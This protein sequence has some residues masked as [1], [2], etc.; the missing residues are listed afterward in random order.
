MKMQKSISLTCAT[1]G[2]K[3]DD[4]EFLNSKLYY[5]KAQKDILK[6]KQLFIN[7][8]QKLKSLLTLSESI[9]T[10]FEIGIEVAKAYI[11]VGTSYGNAMLEV[12]A[13]VDDQLISNL[14][15]Q[16]G[17]HTSKTIS[18]NSSIQQLLNNTRI[19][20][21]I[22]G[23]LFIIL[24]IVVYLF[25]QKREELHQ[26]HMKLSQAMDSLW[27]EMQL[28][29]KIQTV[30]LPI[31]PKINGFEISGIMIPAD[32]VGG[33]YFDVINADGV[34]WL[35]IGDVSGHGVPAGLIMMMAQTSI[36]TIL[37]QHPNISPSKLLTILNKV[38]SKNIKNLG[39]EKYMT[40]SALS[41]NDKGEV[42][43]SGLHQDIML[44]RADC[45]MV[46]RIETNGIW[47][48]IFDDIDRISSDESF[49]MN[50]GDIV[51]LFTDG[52]TEATDERD[53]MFSDEKLLE[54]FRRFCNMDSIDAIQ[55]GILKELES[56]HKSDDITLLMA[57]RI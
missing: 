47:L 21:I 20:F 30:L 35:I 50:H 32:D 8:P 15:S 11:E 14:S 28:A 33:D 1:R 34:N 55:D 17:E 43:F 49:K 57:K 51:L 26:S 42:T 10:Y 27:G 48:G 37:N 18:I 41:A 25:M 12:F 53:V 24:S 9:D 54:I 38:L 29:K 31:N 22:M 3:E 40:L 13:I 45:D 6:L 23:F 36:Q 46:E 39:E 5:D 7:D 44:Y 2:E 56:Y 52:I 4:N 19:L 16:I